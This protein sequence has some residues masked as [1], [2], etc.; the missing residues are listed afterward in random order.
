[1]IHKYL[2][3]ETH[4]Y[5][6]HIETTQL[7]LSEVRF[8]SKLAQRSKQVIVRLKTVE[9]KADYDLIFGMRK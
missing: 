9:D 7:M 2:E 4:F 6:G 5:D 3:C 1:M 8:I